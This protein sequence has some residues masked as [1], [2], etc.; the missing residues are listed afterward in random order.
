[1]FIQLALGS[2]NE[3]KGSIKRLQVD[4]LKKAKHKNDTDEGVYKLLEGVLGENNLIFRG[5]SYVNLKTYTKPSFTISLDTV[6]KDGKTNVIGVDRNSEVLDKLLA[7][8]NVEKTL[9]SNNYKFPIIQSFGNTKYILSNLKD[10]SGEISDSLGKAY[11]KNI[12]EN[13]E[14][15]AEGMSATYIKMPDSISTNTAK[16]IHYTA[17]EI[18]RLNKLVY[19]N[20]DTKVV[21]DA[22]EDWN[23][24]DIVQEE[25]APVSVDQYKPT[26]TQGNKTFAEY[27][28]IVKDLGIMGTITEEEYDLLS[29]AEQSTL[30]EQAKNCGL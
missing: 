23:S 24:S 9:D 13:T 1:M 16:P 17:D 25:V 26:I 4:N 20:K 22:S 10:D 28:T 2:D 3:S 11:L 29:N 6:V 12:S 18:L 19:T 5:K 14:F 8:F 15:S 30:I 21:L 7:R 27:Q